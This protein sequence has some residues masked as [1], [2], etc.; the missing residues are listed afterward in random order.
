MTRPARACIDL[1]SLQHNFSR[2]RE[3]APGC[4]IM[5]IIKANAYGHGLV[6]VAQSLPDA[7]AF[8]IVSVDEGIALREAGFDRRIILLEGLFTR[9]DV[10][11]VNGYRLDTVVHHDYQLQILEQAGLTR[12]HDVWVKLD[13]GMN[14]LGFDPADAARLTTRLRGI[15][16]VADIRYMTHLACADEPDRETTRLQR[17]RFDEALGGLEGE[18]SLAN[19]A[20]VLAW[21]DTH[22]DWVRPGIMLYGGSPLEG[23]SADELDLRPVM[24]L[25]TR[26]IA[27]NRRRRGEAVGYGGEWVCPEDMPVG[28]AAI[29]Y[30]DGYP[31]HAP[32]GVPVLVRGERAALIGRVSMDMICIDLRGHDGA[33]VGDEVV[34]WGEGL[35]VEEVAAMAGTISYELLCGISPRVRREYLST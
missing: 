17:E 19:S 23:R 10:A 28:V 21:P 26:L 32:S 30:G 6:R 27:V 13:T 15:G 18:R 33:A 29:G 31:R 4:Q 3:A 12:P 22:A 14:R 24:T 1:R 5:A 25:R 2:V 20:G 7:D 8:G 35:P 34:L 11:L 9:E 16:R